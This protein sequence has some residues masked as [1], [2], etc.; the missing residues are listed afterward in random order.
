MVQMR[1]IYAI[2][3]PQNRIF[4][5]FRATFLSIFTLSS[6]S[7][8]RRVFRQR[9]K[10]FPPA[11]KRFRHWGKW[12]LEN[13]FHFLHWGKSNPAPRFRFRHWGKSNPAPRFRFLHWGKSNPAPRFYFLHCPKCFQSYFS[14]CKDTHF[15]MGR[16]VYRATSRNIVKK[17]LWYHRLSTIVHLPSTIVHLPSTIVHLPSTIL[18][19]LS[20][21]DNK[22]TRA[23]TMSF[24]FVISFSSLE[25]AERLSSCSLAF[26]F[27]L[28][29]RYFPS[30]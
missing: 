27:L 4:T 24:S 26:L 16:F 17:K 22:P 1:F 21:I 28:C 7:R 14:W 3:L 15:L 18:H 9:G 12:F 11:G 8:V 13:R 5:L 10:C 23:S 30:Q 19:L 2:F 20:S 29:V 25:S 6:L